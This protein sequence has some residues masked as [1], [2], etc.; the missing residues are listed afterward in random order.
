VIILVALL[1]AIEEIFRATIS[2]VQSLLILVLLSVR[3]KDTN[4]MQHRMEENVFVLIALEELV[5]QLK[6]SV[7]LIVMVIVVKSVVQHGGILCIEFQKI[8]THDI[9]Q[10]PPPMILHQF[11]A[12]SNTRQ[13]CMKV[14]GC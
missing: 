1:M 6:V 3:V 13:S 4:I 8:C 12:D 10:I 2:L 11:L 14:D 9:L 7:V 5:E